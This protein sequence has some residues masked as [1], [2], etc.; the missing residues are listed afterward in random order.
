VAS[1][2]AIARRAGFPRCARLVA[3]ILASSEDANLPWHRIVRSDGRL[4]LPTGSDAYREQ[5]AR[6]LAEGVEVE[7]G[8]VRM[9]RDADDWLDAVLWADTET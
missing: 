8:R 3:R 9:R 6:L 4:G 7:G 2:G 5:C 1:Y